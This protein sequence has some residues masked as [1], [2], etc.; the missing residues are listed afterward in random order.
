VTAG[1]S[2]R[3]SQQRQIWREAAPV[4]GGAFPRFG[5]RGWAFSESRKRVVVSSR[6][7]RRAVRGARGAAGGGVRMPG[8]SPD[9]ASILQ[10]HSWSAGAGVPA[11]QVIS[12]TG[13]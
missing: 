7:W 4:R 3:C 9:A 6:V 12:S 2:N 13:T 8:V 1:E 11:Q 10:A 5:K